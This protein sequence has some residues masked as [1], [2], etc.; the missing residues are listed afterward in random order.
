MVK[1]YCI[2]VNFLACVMIGWAGGLMAQNTGSPLTIQLKAISSTT[3][4]ITETNTSAHEIFFPCGKPN[5]KVYVVKGDGTPAEDTDEGIKYKAVERGEISNKQSV[6]V[7]GSMKPGQTVKYPMDVSHLYKISG[8]NQYIVRVEQTVDGIPTAK[9]NS[10]TVG[11][12]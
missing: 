3:V 5:M 12:K 10:V 11:E 2:R 7:S 6:C 4:E 9:S 1:P 8:S